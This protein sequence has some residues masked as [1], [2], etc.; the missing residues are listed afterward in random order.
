MMGLFNLIWTG[1]KGLGKLLVLPIVAIRERPRIPVWLLWGLHIV[2]V[3][4]ALGGLGWLG[5]WMGLDGDVAA[6]SEFLRRTWLPLLCLLTYAGGWV[7]WWLVRQLRAPAE[8]GEHPDL[9]EAWQ[10][11]LHALDRAGIDLASTPLYLVLGK[12]A[13]PE[14]TFFQAA[15]HAAGGGA[16]RRW[17]SATAGLCPAG[18]RVRVYER[19]LAAGRDGASAGD[20]AAA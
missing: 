14:L 6:H 16:N 20:R 10:D 4:L 15:A 2:L 12:P 7:A 19:R 9:D 1:L 5:Y 17:R 3:A 18:R 13:G 8:Q 11:A